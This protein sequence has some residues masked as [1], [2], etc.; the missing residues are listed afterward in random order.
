[1][2]LRRTLGGSDMSFDYFKKIKLGDVAD[3]LSGYAFKTT[4][5]KEDGIPVIKIKNIIPPNIDISDV[6]YVSQELYLEKAK[7]ALKYNDVLI[8][9]TGSNINQIASAVGKI[10]RNKHKNKKLLLNQRVG[11]LLITDEKNSDYDFLYYYLTQDKVRYSLAAS[12]GGSANQANISPK[13][14]KNIEISI[15]TLAEQKAIANILSSLD[16]KIE[17]NNQI[18]KKLEE[19]AQAIFKQWF[20]DYEFP[21][22]EG[23]PYKSSGG[24]MFETEFG[25]IPEG[26]EVKS[27]EEFC[28]VQKGLSYKGKHLVESGVPLI[29]L[30]NV[31]PGGGFRKEKCK[32]Y[33]GEYKHQHEVQ[34][35]D[36]VIA[37]TDMTQERVILGSPAFVPNLK[38]KKI[39]FTH[40]LFAFRNLK[41]PK[42][43]LYYFLKSK[44]FRER[45]ESY[46]TGTTVLAISKSSV[47]NINF[48]LPD[49]ETL[50]LFSVTVKPFLLKIKNINE[51]NVGLEKMRDILLPKLMSGEIRVPIDKE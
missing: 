29:N 51:E 47:L 36:I 34:V 28:D 17:V 20:V 18:N 15:P 3:I 31:Q 16:E 32:Y 30:G 7:Y 24:A 10:G 39:I 42:E 5:F 14:I 27:L 45:A 2:R 43:Y 35:D 49:K 26:W 12:A 25:I 8:S 4:D 46:A 21:N 38:S 33:D 6:Q 50:D 37:N 9:M 48:V 1:M 19:M 11:K 13:Q 41:L 22:A 40:H 44:S 23:K